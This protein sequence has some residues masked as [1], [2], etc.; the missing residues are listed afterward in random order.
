[1][2]RSER[3]FISG[4]AREKKSGTFLEGSQAL[5]ARPSGEKT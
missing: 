5:H 2:E 1:M 4:R 3:R